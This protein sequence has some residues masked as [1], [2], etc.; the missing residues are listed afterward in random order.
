[1]YTVH[2]HT[3]TI[4]PKRNNYCTHQTQTTPRAH[5]NLLSWALVSTCRR[6]EW[7]SQPGRLPIISIMLCN[8]TNS[9]HDW[10]AAKER[11]L[12]CHN[13]T[14]VFFTYYIY[15]YMVSP[16]LST[17]AV[18]W[19]IHEVVHGDASFKWSFAWG[20]KWRNS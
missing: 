9:Q 17:L 1:M 7:D 12:S 15:I 11:K 13:S 6:S 4:P 10:V 18:H 8:K 5:I 14:T 16:Q 3:L 2:I 19:K 20:A